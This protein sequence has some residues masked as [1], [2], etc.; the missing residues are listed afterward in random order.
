MTDISI[1]QMSKKFGVTYRT[2]RF[3]E[4]IGLLKPNR[5]GQTRAFTPLDQ[6]TMALIQHGKKLGLE[7]SEIQTCISTDRTTL[8]I[9]PELAL[10]L[11]FKAEFALCDAQ[12][13]SQDLQSLIP[14]QMKAPYRF[15]AEMTP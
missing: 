5:W 3:Y 7:L 11:R 13:L 10:D 9:P 14:Q 12:K 4:S 2:L 1:A 6:R 8:T 15:V